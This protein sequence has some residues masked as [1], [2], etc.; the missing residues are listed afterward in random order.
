MAEIVVSEFM[1][2]GAVDELRADFDV[3]YDP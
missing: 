1:D 3:R 2:I